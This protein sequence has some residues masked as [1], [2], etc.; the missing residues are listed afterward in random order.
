MCCSRMGEDLV[1]PHW[2]GTCSRAL[3]CL[4]TCT[5]ALFSWPA[6]VGLLLEEVGMAEEEGEAEEA[7]EELALESVEEGV[8][9]DSELEGDEA[10]WARKDTNGRVSV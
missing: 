6:I 8:A 10:S 4:E 7:G 1:G 5:S 9:R 2:R 3:D